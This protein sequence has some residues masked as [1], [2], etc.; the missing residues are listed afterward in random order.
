METF[1]LKDRQRVTCIIKKNKLINIRKETLGYKK[2]YLAI[3]V[4]PKLVA[5]SISYQKRNETE[6]AYQ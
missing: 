4:D 5:I 3:L 2:C 6:I 1:Q